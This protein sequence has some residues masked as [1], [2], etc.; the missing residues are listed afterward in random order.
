MKY[1]KSNFKQY[2]VYSCSAIFFHALS[3]IPKGPPPEEIDYHCYR[4]EPCIETGAFFNNGGS[5]KFR[6]MI[7]KSVFQ[8]TEI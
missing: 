8:K 6:K 1:M 7:P 4:I 3:L 2:F 5:Q